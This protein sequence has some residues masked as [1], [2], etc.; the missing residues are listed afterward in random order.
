MNWELLRRLMRTV[1]PTTFNDRVLRPRRLH[2]F[3]AQPNTD[4]IAIFLI[5]PKT[6]LQDSHLHSLRYM[7]EN[8]YSPFVVSNLPLSDADIDKL[9]P[10]SWRIMI[11]QNF[12][13]DFG[14]YR[15]AI[16]DLAP[17]L[18]HLRTLVFFNDSNWFPI[19]GKM[20][21][22]KTAEETSADFVGAT[23]SGFTGKFSM[24]NFRNNKWH[25]RTT[26]RNFHYGSFAIM[27]KRNILNTPDFEIFWRRLRISLGKTRT[28]RR[29][30]RGFTKWALTRQ[31]SHAA[32]SDHRHFDR[33]LATKS[34]EE[35]RH[36]LQNIILAQDKKA[37]AFF[38]EFNIRAESEH[39]LIE[40]V[41]ALIRTIV[42]RRGLSA[43]LPQVLIKDFNYAFLKKYPAKEKLSSRDRMANI[44]RDLPEP[45]KSIIQN[46]ACLEK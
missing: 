4:K 32:T 25:F 43:S 27:I 17:R 28:I 9:T 37:E 11:R 16:L 42:G 20:N 22:L 2:L 7:I 6:G 14:G 38:Q 41:D 24:K 26:A 44:V 46:E 45:I 40:N 8:G 30:E 34:P 35:K 12:G 15:D 3:G 31:H 21:W 36:M 13:Y 33:L 29:G 19:P 39:M 5:F 23:V 10:V 1:F 18:R